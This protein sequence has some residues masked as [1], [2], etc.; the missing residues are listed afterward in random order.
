[1]E[2]NM[3]T[4]IVI[5]AIGVTFALPE[6]NNYLQNE[7]RYLDEVI[8]GAREIE[9]RE[10]SAKTPPPGLQAPRPEISADI[11]SG[12]ENLEGGIRKLPGY[13]ISNVKRIQE[14]G[15]AGIAYE[16]PKLKAAGQAIGKEIGKGVHSFSKAVGKDMVAQTKE[17]GVHAKPK[18]RE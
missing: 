4:G 7:D 13:T 12:V 3:L 8:A 18:S 6:L 17:S 5:G 14:H 9:R 11:G 1:M 2:H 16:D 15:L 10:T